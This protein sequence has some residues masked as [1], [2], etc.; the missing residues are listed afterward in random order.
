M[1]TLTIGKEKLLQELTK[2]IQKNQTFEGIRINGNSLEEAVK[3]QSRDE[4]K[5]L[6]LSIEKI[7][8]QDEKDFTLDV[9]INQQNSRVYSKVGKK[10]SAQPNAC[11][12][13]RN[14]QS[15]RVI[16]SA[17]ISCHSATKP[18][19]VNEKNLKVNTQHYKKH[20]RNN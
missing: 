7:V 2:L 14:R 5:E 19:F 6:V 11:F 9:S 16:V 15:I 10:S 17:C 20:L 13:K 8:F 3:G 18:F 12:T 1:V 4:R